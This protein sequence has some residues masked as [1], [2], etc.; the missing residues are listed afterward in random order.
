[1]KLNQLSFKDL[2]IKEFIIGGV[3]FSLIK[4]TADNVSDIRISSMIA[5]FPLGLLSSL[6]I[7]DKKILPYSLSYVKN[8]V[9]LLAVSTVFY[10]LNALTNLH[11]HYKLLIS[12]IFW[13]V[14]NYMI[15]SF[16]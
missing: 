2:S 4:Y 8:I 10:L 15:L 14:I 12:I 11:R 13:V 6:L 5:A 16:T 1:M 7:A 3:L 9:I